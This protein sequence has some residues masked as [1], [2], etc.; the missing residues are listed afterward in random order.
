MGLSGA[1]KYAGKVLRN[2]KEVVLAAVN[3]NGKALIYASEGLRDDREVVLAA[4][5]RNADALQCA[6]NGLRNGSHR[7]VPPSRPP[8]E[9]GTRDLPCSTPSQRTPCVLREVPEAAAMG[10]SSL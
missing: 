3:Q 7:H 1:L 6:S 2:D 10:V 4:A 5:H 9:P 8:P